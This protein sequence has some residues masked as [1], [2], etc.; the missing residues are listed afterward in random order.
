MSIAEFDP[1]AFLEQLLQ[2]N[3]DFL[4]EDFDEESSSDNNIADF[5]NDD[6]EI[7]IP[8]FGRTCIAD[9]DRLKNE[10]MVMRSIDM[11]VCLMLEMFIEFSS[12]EK[13]YFL[14]NIHFIFWLSLNNCLTSS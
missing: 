7:A 6:D 10:T 14:Y 11:M 1:E 2:H 5:E 3:D 8:S 13:L 4:L 12:N 9:L